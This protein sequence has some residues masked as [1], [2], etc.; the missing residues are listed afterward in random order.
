MMMRNIA[1]AAV[2]IESRVVAARPAAAAFHTSKSAASNFHPIA[3][4][5]YLPAFS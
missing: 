3:M 5:S 2:R 4:V 1:L